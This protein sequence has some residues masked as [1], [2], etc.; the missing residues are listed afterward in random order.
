MTSAALRA[1]LEE[2]AKSRQ[3]VLLAVDP[4]TLEILAAQ[5]PG[6]GAKVTPI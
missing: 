3:P 6:E 4:R 5:K 1:V 2:A